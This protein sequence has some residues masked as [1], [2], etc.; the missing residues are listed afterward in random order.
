LS[1]RTNEADLA[2]I[3]K[4]PRIPKRHGALIEALEGHVALLHEYARRAFNNDEADFL[5][6]IVGKLRLLAC[7]TPTNKPLLIGLM[8]ELGVDERITL[9][10]PPI[11]RRPGH[12]RA[13]DQVTL[14]EYMETDAFGATLST[15]EF[16]MLTVRQFVLA[17]AQQCGAAHEDW[18]IDEDLRLALDPSVEIGE[19]PAASAALSEPT[20]IVLDIAERALRKIGS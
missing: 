9:S 5:G 11:L 20:K 18:Q 13:G 8:E 15:G 3:P 14:R 17:W 16:K 1:S 19:E 2:K 10:G 7:E 4:P 12:P 6:E